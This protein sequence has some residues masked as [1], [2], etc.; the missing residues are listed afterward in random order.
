[1]GT[2]GRRV[3]TKAGSLAERTGAKGEGVIEVVTE[4]IRTEVRDNEVVLTLK[5]N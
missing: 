3:E 1:M 2:A 4:S 5:E